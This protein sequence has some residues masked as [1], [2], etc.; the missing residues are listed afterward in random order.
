MPVTHLINSTP[1]GRCAHEQ[2]IPDDDLHAHATET[3]ERADLVLFGAGTYSLLAPHWSEVFQTGTGT[4]NELRFARSLAAL[5][6][7]LFSR[8][9]DRIEGWNTTV[10]RDDP[11][12][13]VLDL[14]AAGD[15]EIVVQAS[16]RLAATLRKAG[17]V[18]RM[19]LLLQP[20]VAGTGPP[21]FGEDEALRLELQSVSAHRSGAVALDYAVDRTASTSSP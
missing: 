8:S 16:P 21:L 15:P 19:R 11:V 4:A 10:D 20:M 6:K 18:D 13:R 9:T 7:I 12:V 14:L 17:L 5:P 2:V 1:D 3:L